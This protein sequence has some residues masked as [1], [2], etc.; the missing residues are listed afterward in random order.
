MM[1][2]IDLVIWIL[3]IFLI[4]RCIYNLIEILLIAFFDNYQFKLLN[5][6]C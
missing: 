2:P 4:L 5:Q 6:F 1:R 3:R